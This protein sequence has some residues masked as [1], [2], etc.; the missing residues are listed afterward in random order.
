MVYT[1]KQSGLSVKK[2]KRNGEWS[3]YKHNM[4]LFTGIES[5]QSAK[6]IMMNQFKR[7]KSLRG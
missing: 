4:A 7:E 2:G 3:V 5:K 1:L 6:R